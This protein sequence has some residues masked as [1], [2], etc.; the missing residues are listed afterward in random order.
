[1]ATANDEDDDCNDEQGVLIPPINQ[2]LDVDC[3][4]QILL[5]IEKEV[6]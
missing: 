4:A 2:I 1:M 6:T 5:V 3:H